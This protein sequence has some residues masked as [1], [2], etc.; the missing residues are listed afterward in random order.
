MCPLSKIMYYYVASMI[1]RWY[2]NICCHNASSVCIRWTTLLIL[3]QNLEFLGPIQQLLVSLQM[4][5]VFEQKPPKYT[6]PKLNGGDPFEAIDDLVTANL[7]QEKVGDRCRNIDWLPDNLK[8]LI[9][10]YMPNEAM[11]HQGSIFELWKVAVSFNHKSWV[12]LM[13]NR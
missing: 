12:G 8:D 1:Y 6:P 2:C 4:S 5:E 3:L 10:Q 13:P 9:D 11:D 7:S